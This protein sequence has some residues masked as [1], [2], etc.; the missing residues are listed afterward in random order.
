VPAIETP[1]LHRRRLC[2]V[3]V[4]RF[5]GVPPTVGPSPAQGRL[6]ADEAASMQM[7]AQRNRSTRHARRFAVVAR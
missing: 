1:A 4:S 3:Q 5:E 2:A 6:Y 7:D